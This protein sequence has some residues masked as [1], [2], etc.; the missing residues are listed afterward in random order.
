MVH[1]RLV[2]DGR[3]NFISRFALL[4]CPLAVSNFCFSK[5]FANFVGTYEVFVK[6]PQKPRMPPIRNF[7]SI[8]HGCPSLTEGD[9]ETAVVL[10]L[11]LVERFPSYKSSQTIGSTSHASKATRRVTNSHAHNRLISDELYCAIAQ[12]ESGIKR[13]VV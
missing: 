12:Y 8:A 1:R 13:K 2:S 11:W 6:L 10:K 3:L 4:A 9:R 5:L 7:C